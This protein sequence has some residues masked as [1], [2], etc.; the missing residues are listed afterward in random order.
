MRVLQSTS[1]RYLALYSYCWGILASTGTKFKFSRPPVSGPLPTLKYSSKVP[2]NLNL[3][4]VPV[5]V[6]LNV[7]VQLYR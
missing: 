1:T 6:S 3:N 7:H 5:S 2:S 4:L